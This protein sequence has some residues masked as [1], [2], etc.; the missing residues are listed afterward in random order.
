M[1]EVLKRALLAA[2]VIAV[3]AGCSSSGAGSGTESN[4]LPC[5]TNAD[6]PTGACVSGKCSASDAGSLPEAGQPDAG[7]PDGARPDSGHPDAASV[8]SGHLPATPDAT[9]DVVV[10]AR[11]GGDATPDGG[12]AATTEGGSGST[13]RD[14]LLGLWSFDGNGQDRSRAGAD[15]RITGGTFVSG[16]FG[17]ALQFVPGTEGFAVRQ[18]APTSADAITDAI[19]SSDFT[20]ALWV[21][22]TDS[23][24]V[25][26]MAQPNGWNLAYYDTTGFQIVHPVFLGA[27]FPG[28][29][30]R[31]P[32]SFRHLVV[33]RGGTTLR[34]FVDGV[35]AVSREAVAAPMPP[36]DNS[37]YLGYP[38]STLADRGLLLD[39][40]AIWGRAL[41]ADERASLLTQPVPAR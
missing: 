20:I 5:N 13:L 38:N 26:L 25:Y 35:E 39:D 29:A 41:T 30:T 31:V 28:T 32:G 36:S 19:T 9:S 22:I 2:T 10:D 3:L 23:L 40:V 17:Q 27:N 14:G 37:L 8:D 33:T 15:M 12:D 1:N 6:C 21:Q 4:F 11:T 7:Q 18:V 34:V 16:K 24:N